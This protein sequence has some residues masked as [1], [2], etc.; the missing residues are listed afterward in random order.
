VAGEVDSRHVPPLLELLTAELE[1]PRQISPQVVNHI[2]E[3]YGLTREEI[4]AF[5]TN[6]L[7]KLEDYEIDLI[8]SPLFTPTLRDQSGFADLLGSDSIPVT[9]WPGM[10]QQLVNRPTVA[11]LITED[12]VTHAIPLRAVTVE[13]FVHRLRLEGSIREPLLKL[14]EALPTADHPLLK[15][16]ARRAIWNTDGRREILSHYLTNAKRKGSYRSEDAVELLKLAETYQPENTT[17]LLKRL[18][19]WEQVLQQEITEAGN[20]KPFFNERVQDLH[21]GGRDQR[22]LDNSRTTAKENELAFL[23]RLQETLTASD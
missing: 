9:E 2:V 1:R 21:G 15:A 11:H 4:G 18:P 3:T 10:V 19:H 16:T 20:P 13:R 5:L 14:I 8:L 22:R 17:E 7:T 6:E 23:K 12:G